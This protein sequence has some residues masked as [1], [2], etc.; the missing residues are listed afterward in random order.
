M[1]GT[2]NSCCKWKEILSKDLPRKCLPNCFDPL[3]GPCPDYKIVDVVNQ[4]SSDVK[5]I[6]EPEP[7]VRRLIDI[8]PLSA[9]NNEIPE[10]PCT[11]C[12]AQN[13]TH[14]NNFCSADCRPP[15][16]SLH[17]NEWIKRPQAKPNYKH[18]VF[19][20][21]ELLV[22]RIFPCKF[23]IRRVKKNCNDCGK[24]LYLRDPITD[25]TNVVVLMNC[26]DVK[27]YHDRVLQNWHRVPILSISGDNAM[28]KKTI[29]EI[30]QLEPKKITPVVQV[31]QDNTI[32]L[33]EIVS[34]KKRK[35]KDHDAECWIYWISFWKTVGEHLLR[36]PIAIVL[37]KALYCS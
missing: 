28:K 10:K 1:A 13:A 2:R 33:P 37:R 35:G 7:P 31:K 23:R 17:L 29:N 15:S 8:K 16:T 24:Q 26:C 9:K 27:V 11:L 36:F 5:A 30:C 3:H 19:L 14:P 6:L 4:L 20:N 22:G 21:N 18:S 25:N 12:D 32:K 34:K